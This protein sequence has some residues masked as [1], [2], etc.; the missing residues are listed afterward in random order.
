MKYPKISSESIRL[1]DSKNEPLCM[2]EAF[3]T[4]K[5]MPFL[6]V[7]E[8]V[9]AGST[10]ATAT[11]FVF[12]APTKI[13]IERVNFI[14]TTVQTGTGNLPVVKLGEG[15]NVIAESEEIALAGS[16]G[17]VI[18]LVVDDEKCVLNEGTALKFL[19]VNAAGTITTAL[20][21]KLQVEFTSV[22]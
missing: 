11:S 22:I 3:H 13:K 2:H 18:P 9:A 12:V 14:M 17:S 1:R 21:G 6:F 15:S 10:G 20:K 8:E 4:V 7:T 5:D 16:I 19:I